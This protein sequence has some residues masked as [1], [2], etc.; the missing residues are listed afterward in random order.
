[1]AFAERPLVRVGLIRIPVAKRCE[2]CNSDPIT[3]ASDFA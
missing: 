2:T 3:I 1:M